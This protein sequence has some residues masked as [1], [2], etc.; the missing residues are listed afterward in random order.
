MRRKL[1][2]LFVLVVTLTVIL[3]ATPARA[4]GPRLIW[5]DR[6][7]VNGMVAGSQITASLRVNAGEEV[8]VYRDGVLQSV[9]EPD[10]IAPRVIRH[11]ISLDEPA[12]IY[13][14]IRGLSWMGGAVKYVS[15]LF[16]LRQVCGGPVVEEVTANPWRDD[17][18]VRV[19]SPDGVPITEALFVKRRGIMVTSEVDGYRLRVP[20][21]FGPGK[22]N[23][24]FRDALGQEVS[25]SI[26]Y[27]Y[28]SL[29]QRIWN[30]LTL[31]LNVLLLTAVIVQ[32]VVW[33]RCW[34]VGR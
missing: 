10:S 26:P 20:W 30:A 19:G 33:R 6:P 9:Y 5:F 3:L 31:V 21:R 17:I 18:K 11:T 24:T 25:I 7:I 15:P 13:F 14:Q 23:A 4:D 22:V 28:W 12:S 27:S 32:L 2:I 34:E 29:G 8:Y 16:T 1:N